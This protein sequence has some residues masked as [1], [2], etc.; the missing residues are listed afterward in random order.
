MVGSHCYLMANCHVAHDCRLGDRIIMA[1]GTLLG[2]HVHI[3][4]D[5]TLS[6]I[7]AAVHHFTTIGQFS[8]ERLSCAAR[9]AAV[10]AGGR[11]MP[12]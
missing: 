7:A 9:C 11:G 6:E 1:N 8:R 5:A 3:H 4:D 2:G 12:A 10:H